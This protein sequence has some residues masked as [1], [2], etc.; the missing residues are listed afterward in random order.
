M[1]NNGYEQGNLRNFGEYF[2]K[3]I[4]FYDLKNEKLGR[5]IFLVILLTGLAELLIPENIYF[6]SIFGVIRLTLVHFASTIYLYAYLKQLKGETC[7]TKAYIHYIF[8]NAAAIMISSVSFIASLLMLLGILIAP[9]GTSYVITILSIPVL[10]LYLIY[11]FNI[12]FIV[13][14]KVTVAD[15]FKLSSKATRGLKGRIFKI[16][17]IMYLLLSVPLT[18]VLLPVYLSNSSLVSA[19]VFLF[20]SSI[21]SLIQQRLTALMYIDLKYGKGAKI[22]DETNSGNSDR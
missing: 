1:I 7:N 13:D 12:C 18:F 3:S 17:F 11:F 21:I 20:I 15:S 14:A 5:Y 19:F 4:K 22:Y 2:S 16:I 9:I 6:L 8:K 10:L